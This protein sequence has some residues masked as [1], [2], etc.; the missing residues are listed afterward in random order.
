LREQPISTAASPPVGDGH[1]SAQYIWGLAHVLL[2]PPLVS[3]STNLYS[4]TSTQP[5]A[6]TAIE[7][8]VC[9]LSAALSLFPTVAPLSVWWQLVRQTGA[10]SLYAGLLAAAA[11]LS[12]RLSQHLWAPT[13][14][15][16]RP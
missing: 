11:V 1:R 9:A 5:F 16:R 12:I 7:R 13:A 2:L 14:A 15:I 3:L 8:H 6:V 10:L 4:A